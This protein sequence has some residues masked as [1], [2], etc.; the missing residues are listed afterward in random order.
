MKHRVQAKQFNR[1]TNSRKAL[2]MNLVRNL[3]E[4]GEITT[5]ESR[6]KEAARLTNKLIGVAKAGDLTARRQLHRF[7]GKRDV[8]N[9]LVD[10]VAPAMTEKVS[11][12]T[13]LKKV[14]QRRGDNTELYK[15]SILAETKTWTSLN[16]DARQAKKVEAKVSAAKAKKASKKA[17][18]AEADNKTTDSTVKLAQFAQK[19]KANLAK[20]SAVNVRNFTRRKTGD[21]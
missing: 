15:V 7:F 4:H 17:S 6:A 1:D 12:F 16:N 11:G 8:V 2:L 13:A 21:K 19:E 9:T 5:S 14:A 20:T 10:K 3:I 18:K